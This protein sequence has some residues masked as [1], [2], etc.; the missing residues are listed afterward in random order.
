MRR[1]L[2]LLIRYTPVLILAAAWE[3]ISRAGLISQYALPPLSTVIV[4]WVG[5][6]GDATF[7]YHAGM[8]LAR[9]AVG[10]CLAVVIGVVLGIAMASFR[11]VDATFGPIVKLFYP[12][13][14]SALIPLTI[15]WFGLGDSSKIFLIFLG[16]LLPITLSSFNG[17]KGV[18]K[19]L[20][21]SSASLGASHWARIRDVVFPASAP[22][23]LAG[24]RTALALAF[25][26]LVSSELVIA[27]NGLGY[28]IRMTG[29]GGQYAAMFAVVCTVVAI[30]FVADRLLLKLTAWVLRWQQ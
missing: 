7:Y 17:A 2:D 11:W 16:C 15:L 12:M 26:L 3:G 5:F 25:V 10:L 1:T 23:I 18:D 14:K 6:L 24:L 13:P 22:M 30:G 8:S 19:V 28:L 4:A 9:A 27:N 29:D 20:L 21:W